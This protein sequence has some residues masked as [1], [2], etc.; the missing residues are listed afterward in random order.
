MRMR[1][2]YSQTKLIFRHLGKS[3]K[4]ETCLSPLLLYNTVNEVDYNF[5]Y[6]F[7]LCHIS[8]TSRKSFTAD[9]I[10]L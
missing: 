10:L 1:L 2:H 4:Q 7:T 6:I 9:V 8:I 5:L 3:C